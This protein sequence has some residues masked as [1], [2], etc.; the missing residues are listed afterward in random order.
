MSLGEK[1]L[2]VKMLEDYISDWKKLDGG[3]LLFP[4]SHLHFNKLFIRSRFVFMDRVFDFSGVT[5]LVP[6]KRM[7]EAS[8]RLHRSLVGLGCELFWSGTILRRPR[9]KNYSVLN[10]LQK[11]VP[12]L[13][14]SDKLTN[15]LNEPGPV[16]ELVRKAR[17]D[18]LY[19]TLSSFTE[20]SHPVEPSFDPI[21]ALVK[22]YH[23]P[24]EIAWVTSL[25]K[26]ISRTV[27]YKESFI[28]LLRLIDSISEVVLKIGQEP[29]K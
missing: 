15:A 17:P 9:F 28:N 24:T 12:D 22:C 23:K 5:E 4:K 19:V 29:S 10:V 1:P 8:R 25:N 18:E 21:K 7:D 14:I 13:E 26:L 16:M 2:E 20:P 3:I 27:G 6:K 11:H